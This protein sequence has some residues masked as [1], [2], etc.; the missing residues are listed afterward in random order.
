MDA[1]CKH[2]ISDALAM[3]RKEIRRSSDARYDHRLHALLLVAGGLSCATAADALG[4]PE[5]TVQYW[6]HRF[7]T[8]GLVGLVEDPRPGRPPRLDRPQRDHL[9]TV[10]RASP[11]QAGLSA[12]AWDGNSL[13]SFIAA[14]F[15]V[16]LSARQCQRVLQEL[17]G[18]SHRSQQARLRGRRVNLAPQAP[19]PATARPARS[20]ITDR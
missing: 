12:S 5:R 1:R 7:E 8:E 17:G 14:Q 11:Q 19:P 6:V 13:S 20:G 10:L 2:D 15:G 3:L 16:E 18:P 4:E 9:R